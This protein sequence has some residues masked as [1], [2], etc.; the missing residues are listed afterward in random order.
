MADEETRE[1]RFLVN[2]R[3]KYGLRRAELRGSIRWLLKR[4][5]IEINVDPLS[6]EGRRKLKRAFTSGNRH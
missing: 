1:K 4:R 3:V 2:D 5:G 6:F